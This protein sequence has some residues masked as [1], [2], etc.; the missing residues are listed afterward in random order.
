MAPR[1]WRRRGDFTPAAAASRSCRIQLVGIS[2]DMTALAA[3][4]SAA[5]ARLTAL[6]SRSAGAALPAA[7]ADAAAPAAAAGAP[8]ASAAPVARRS[9]AH[10]AMSTSPLL[11]DF[12]GAAD[13]DDDDAAEVAAPAGAGLLPPG[14]SDSDEEVVEWPPEQTGGCFAVAAPLPATA[15]GADGAYDVAA[16]DAA[17]PRFPED[18]TAACTVM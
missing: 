2:E 16:R 15:G 1:A 5:D 17:R 3:L 14:A 7:P 11:Y 10:K 18:E 12:Y 13:D 8:G 9:K 4:L 6:M